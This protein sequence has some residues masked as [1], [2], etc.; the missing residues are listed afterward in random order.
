MH[1]PIKN[2][3]QD[4][5]FLG[6]VKYPS[7]SLQAWFKTVRRKIMLNRDEGGFFYYVALLAGMFLIGTYL[8][9]ILVTPTG[10]QGFHFIMYATG[11]LL[12]VSAFGFAFAKARTS[13]VGLT[14]ITGVIA[15]IH[16]FLEITLFGSFVGVILF[17]WMSFGLLLAFAAFSWLLE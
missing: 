5:V 6:E 13:R 8:W 9:H 7:Y 2:S 3:S 15:G 4:G 16:F 14:V 11:F 10:Y 12:P 17:A 1:C